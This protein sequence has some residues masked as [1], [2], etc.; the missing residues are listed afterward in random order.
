MQN[1]TLNQQATYWGAPVLDGYGSRSFAAPVLIKCRWEDRTGLTIYKNGEEI[2]S[3][4]VVYTDRDVA[5]G[6]YLALG[7]YA[8]TPTADPQTIASA[9]LV[10]D[11]KAIPS[12]DGKTI[13]RKA[14]L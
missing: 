8:T 1:G 5:L 14:I 7:D 4:A 13:L 9:Y 10:Q 3:R 12:V 2:N 11:F 6:G